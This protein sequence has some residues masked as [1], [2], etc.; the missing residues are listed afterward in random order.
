[1]VTC[2]QCNATLLHVDEETPPS[3][4]NC[5]WQF[6]NSGTTGKDAD[7]EQNLTSQAGN[8][9]KCGCSDSP[10]CHTVTGYIPYPCQVTGR[11]G[12]SPKQIYSDIQGDEDIALE[13]PSEVTYQKIK[14]AAGYDRIHVTSASGKWSYYHYLIPQESIFL[15]R[16][17]VWRI[18]LRIMGMHFVRA[19]FFVAL[20]LVFWLFDK[21]CVAT[22]L[23]PQSI[24][25]SSAVGTLLGMV[26]LILGMA[27]LGGVCYG[28]IETCR[29]VTVHFRAA[30]LSNRMRSCLP[31]T[32]PARFFTGWGEVPV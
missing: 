20:V 31:N 24:S 29:G 32:C 5:G 15:C 8:C 22:G 14:N 19:L 4:W 26:G 17:C 18:S 13:K 21:G 28:V 25:S 1:M 9:S 30:G 11:A 23:D 7:P 3:C 27:A 10:Q 16:Q 12:T 6:N 2:P